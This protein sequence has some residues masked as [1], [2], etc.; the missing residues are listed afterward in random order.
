MW[1]G[2]ESGVER[3]ACGRRGTLGVLNVGICTQ[4][5]DRHECVHRDMKGQCWSGWS[6]GCEFGGEGEV[7]NDRY[8]SGMRW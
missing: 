7:D 5:M 3:E 6:R 8:Q 1:S 4:M 2:L